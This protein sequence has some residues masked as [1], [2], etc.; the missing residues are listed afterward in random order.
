MSEYKLTKSTTIERLSDGAWIPPDPVNLDYQKYQDWL[1]KGNTPQAA[2]PDP[3]VVP[4]AK[5]TA[6][7]AVLADGT[8]PASIKA[9]V[10]LL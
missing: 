9:F 2:D 6:K 10:Q 7:A 1:K 8:V 3:V 5:D 4:S